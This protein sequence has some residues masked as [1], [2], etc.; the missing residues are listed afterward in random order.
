M[1]KGLIKKVEKEWKEALEILRDYIAEDYTKRKIVY[2][3][4]IAYSWQSDAAIN[5]EGNFLFSTPNEKQTFDSYPSINLKVGMLAHEILGHSAD[6]DQYYSSHSDLCN[7]YFR[8][9]S[10]EQR[11]NLRVMYI[12]PKELYST[13]KQRAISVFEFLGINFDLGIY[14]EPF[15][16]VESLGRAGLERRDDIP[17]LFKEIYKERK[18]PM[19]KYINNAIVLAF[20]GLAIPPSVWIEKDY[21]I[22][23]R[24]FSLPI[25]HGWVAEYLTGKISEPPQL[26]TTAPE[27]YRPEYSVDLRGIKKEKSLKNLEDEIEVWKRKADKEKRFYYAQDMLKALQIMYGRVKNES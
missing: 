9:M 2:D 15:V 10:P 6:I 17:K 13:H 4:N 27:R 1:N 12:L 7:D 19:D 22:L 16:T 21:G 5:K 24:N 11:A 8:C 20:A 23:E 25:M 26:I 14:E 18:I 3:P